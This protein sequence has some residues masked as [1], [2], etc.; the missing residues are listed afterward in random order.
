MRSQKKVVDQVAIQRRSRQSKAALA[1]RDAKDEARLAELGKAKQAEDDGILKGLVFHG[2]VR[3]AVPLNPGV[4][5]LVIP[6]TV[7]G[8]TV[9]VSGGEYMV[10]GELSLEGP[11]RLADLLRRR[12]LR[13]E[14]H[15]T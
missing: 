4:E 7:E 15:V 2:A 12:R 8:S 14:I 11:T 13:V 3:H 9:R 10:V 6:I 5:R 1:T